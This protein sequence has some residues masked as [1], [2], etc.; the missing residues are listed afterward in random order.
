[1]DLCRLCTTEDLVEWFCHI[2][3]TAEELCEEFDF[4]AEARLTPKQYGLKVKSHEVLTITSPLKM[5]NSQ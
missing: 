2:A 4:M 1:M 3:A 5:R